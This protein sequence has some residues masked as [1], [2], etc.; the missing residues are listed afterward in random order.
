MVPERNGQVLLRL[1]PRFDV[2]S[3]HAAD[4]LGVAHEQL[5]SRDGNLPVPIARQPVAAVLLTLPRR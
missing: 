3:A 2:A 4:Y 5:H 1:R